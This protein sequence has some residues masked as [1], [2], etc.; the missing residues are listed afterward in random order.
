MG[1]HLP[2]SSLSKASA[3][4]RSIQGW[5]KKHYRS[6]CI[7]STK[8]YLPSAVWLSK[9]ERFPFIP[10]ADAN[11]VLGFVKGDVGCVYLLPWQFWDGTHDCIPRERTCQALLSLTHKTTGGTYFF[12]PQNVSGCHHMHISE[13]STFA[14]FEHKTLKVFSMR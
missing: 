2:T 7:K 8:A 12:P 6:T 10:E 4:F 1:N 11:W 9:Q 3:R 5:H 14:D 13:I